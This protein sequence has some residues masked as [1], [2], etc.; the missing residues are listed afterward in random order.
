MASP[1][2]VHVADP[3]RR[4][5]VRIL[6][7]VSREAWRIEAKFS[8]YR[9]GNIVHAINAS[10]GQS[11]RVDDETARLLDYADELFRLS[12]GRFDISSGALRRAWHFDGGDGLPSDEQVRAALAHVGWSRVSWQRPVITL[13]PG[14]EIDLGGIGKEYAV[15]RAASLV[16]PL[17]DACLINFGGDL[18][19]LGAG[20]D[21]QPWRIG[22]ESVDQRDHARHAIELFQGGTATSGDARR[23]LLKDG[24]RYGHILDPTNGWPVPG[25]P[26]SVTVLAE[27]CTQAGMLATFAMLR[28]PDAE[29]FLTEQEVRYWCLR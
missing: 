24:K 6:H 19:A 5:A 15:D 8:R 9:D 21:G 10:A 4:K 22:I 27:T 2:E 3:D 11:V 23:Y 14:M 18:R 1:C 25:A 17:S 29:A 16:G 20:R 26:R 7:L 28:G 12:A 13:E